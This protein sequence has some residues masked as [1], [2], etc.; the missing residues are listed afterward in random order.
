MISFMFVY[1]LHFLVYMKK[2]KSQHCNQPFYKIKV[3]NIK[4]QTYIYRRKCIQK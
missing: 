3:N 1:L 2:I 4:T